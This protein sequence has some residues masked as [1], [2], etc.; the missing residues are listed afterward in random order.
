MD[1]VKDLRF[2][3]K[4]DMSG[5]PKACWSWMG[6]R[7][8]GGYGR[9]NRGGGRANLY[10][11]R[12][13]YEQE[14][15]SVPAGYDVCHHCDTPPCCNPAHLFVGSASDNV[16]DAVSK[17]RCNPRKGESHPRAKLTLR[18]VR[19]IR[20]LLSIGVSR[21]ELSDRHRVC[22]ETIRRIAIGLAWKSA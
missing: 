5:G 11:H 17:G 9:L 6:S 15:G 3:G 13:A 14:F 22:V 12:F 20:K 21:K 18:D 4:V 8:P 7:L 10:A 16:R 19:S 2:W 1:S